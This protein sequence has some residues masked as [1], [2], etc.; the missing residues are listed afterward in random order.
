MP[1]FSDL[2]RRYPKASTYRY[3]YALALLQ[4]GDKSAARR[5]LQACLKNPQPEAQSNKVHALLASLQ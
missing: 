5:E 4:K 3:H 1:V 2:V